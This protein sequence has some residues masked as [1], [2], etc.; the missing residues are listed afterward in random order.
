MRIARAGLLLALALVAEQGRAA[1]A[2]DIVAGQKIAETYCVACHAIGPDGDSPLEAAPRFRE[3]GQ[4]FPIENLEESLA[5]GIMTG[6]PDMPQ[7]EMT[8]DE[9]G[10]FLAYLSS[11]QV[12]AP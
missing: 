5:E 6:H 3:L 7:F 4:R 11:I 1:E 8:P 2:G 10:V 9:I 12:K